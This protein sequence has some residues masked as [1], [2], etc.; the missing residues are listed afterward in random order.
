MTE[1]REGLDCWTNIT[2][3]PPRIVEPI[4]LKP[5]PDQHIVHQ[6]GPEMTD[7]IAAAQSLILQL[8]A[9]AQYHSVWIRTDVDPETKQFVRSLCVSI[10]PA[11]LKNI[12][13][14]DSHMGIPVVQVPWPK[15]S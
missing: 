14:P 7:H 6:R 4:S 12:K 9:P 15:G 5:A 3:I 13:V 2:R 1:F 11:Q 8:N 10:R